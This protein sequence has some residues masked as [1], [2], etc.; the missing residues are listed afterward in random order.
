MTGFYM[1]SAIP[2][3]IF[4]PLNQ[5]EQPKNELKFLKTSPFFKL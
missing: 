4:I 3:H 5:Y 2:R 1:I